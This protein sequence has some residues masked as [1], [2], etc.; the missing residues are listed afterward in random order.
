MFF[1]VTSLQQYP[2]VL[3]LPWLHRH[4]VTANFEE[5][6][7]T[8][9]SPFCLKNCTLSP[10]KVIA[11]DEPFLM[12]KE[13]YE[14][15]KSQE[16][17]QSLASSVHAPGHGLSGQ[18]STQKESPS[19]SAG[20]VLHALQEQAPTRKESPSRSA[21][22]VL[23]ALQEQVPTR[24]ESPSRSAGAVL[25]A[26]QEQVPIQKEST[27]PSVPVK[28][29]HDDEYS[30]ILTA[31]KQGKSPRIKYRSPASMRSKSQRQEWRS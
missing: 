5:I 25:H 18:V 7:L 24:K 17:S 30:R 9:A 27:T 11:E 14:V 1:H 12:P 10:V 23:H 28:P 4:G 8:F 15:M 16:F 2:V 31:A 29:S 19:R 22:A 13:N 20:A 3:G 21:G 26:L 6:S